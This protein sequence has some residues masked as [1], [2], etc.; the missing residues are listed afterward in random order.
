MNVATR[1][2]SIELA[3][4]ETPPTEFLIFRAGVNESSK[5]PT[6]FDDQSARMVMAAYGR[7]GVDL[8]IDLDHMMLDN[9]SLARREDA[10]DARGWF[11]L[12]LRGGE[13]WAVDVRWSPDGA[14]RL[15]QKTQRYISPAF[16]YDDDNRATRLLNV[17][18]LAMPAT[19]G[20]EPLVA[21][22]RL[23]DASARAMLNVSARTRINIDSMLR[24]LSTR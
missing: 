2:L 13:L 19:Y 3:S 17:A 9:P 6:L 22:A 16:T 20:A 4:A 18:M 7:E 5:G 21:A 23:R 10:S 15:E 12:Q 1:K 24:R 11:K 14:R 8:P